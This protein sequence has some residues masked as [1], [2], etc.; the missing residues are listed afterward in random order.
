MYGPPTPIKTGPLGWMIRNFSS[1]AGVPLFR[2]EWRTPL[3]VGDAAR[4]LFELA[5]KGID[6]LYHLGGPDRINRVMLGRE[7]AREYNFDPSLIV[8][9]LREEV[10]STPPRPEDVALNSAQIGNILSFKPRRLP[11]GLLLTRTSR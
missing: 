3:Y 5:S 10:D 7:L 9:K 11:E 4:A 8:E 6:G 2:D 1:G